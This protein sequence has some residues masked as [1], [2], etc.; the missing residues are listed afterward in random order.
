MSDEVGTEMSYE[1]AKDAL[2]QLVDGMPLHLQHLG[3]AVLEE[4]AAGN[5]AKSQTLEQQCVNY[6]QHSGSA[7][8]AIVKKLGRPDELGVDGMQ[9]HVLH[10]EWRRLGARTKKRVLDEIARNYPWLGAECRRQAWLAGVGGESGNFML[11]FG[12]F[13]GYRLRDV[14]IDYLIQLLGQGSV[15]KSFRTCIE[16]HLSERAAGAEVRRENTS[17]AG[18]RQTHEGEWARES[19]SLVPDS[20]VERLKQSV[21]VAE[22]EENGQGKRV[23]RKWACESA[24]GKVLLRLERLEEQLGNDWWQLFRS[25]LNHHPVAARLAFEMDPATR[26]DPK[27]ARVFWEKMA[28]EADPSSEYVRGFVE[29]ALEVWGNVKSRL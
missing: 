24:D 19:A 21:S 4:R 25:D 26:D 8:D 27:A 7:Y 1:T 11:P 29:A 16:R 3:R 9:R 22:A 10:V 18:R 2:Y 28:G 17:R 14:S 15:R 23:G 13:K 5:G 6:L 20:V 12:P